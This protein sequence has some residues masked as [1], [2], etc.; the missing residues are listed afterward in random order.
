MLLRSF[1][2]LACAF[3]FATFSL[4]FISSAKAVEVTSGFSFN[5]IDFD[6]D[7]SPDPNSTT[8]ELT[9][10]PVS[11]QSQTGMSTGFVN[12]YAGGQWIVRNMP[13]GITE[14]SSTT[15]FALP[16]STDGVDDSGLTAYVDY[17]ASPTISFSAAA[18]HN[19]GVGNDDAG[20]EGDGAGDPS[21]PATAP[22]STLTFGG[23]TTAITYQ[24]NHPNIQTARNQCAPMALA[25]NLKWLQDT[26]GVTYVQGATT[27][28]HVTGLKGDPTNSIVGRLDVLMGRTGISGTTNTIANRKT[29]DG[30]FRTNNINGTLQFLTD[31]SNTG[32]VVKNEG[33]D[34]DG[35]T[36]LGGNFTAGAM[37]SQGQGNNLQ[38]SFILS[39][40]QAGDAV[41]MMWKYPNGG[42]H[43]VEVVGA[44]TVLGVNWLWYK[45]DNIQTN[46]KAPDGDSVGTDQ[47][48]WSRLDSS[49]V[50]VDEKNRPTAQFVI[51]EAVPEPGTLVLMALGGATLA[52]A[53]RRNRAA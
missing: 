23:P 24:F 53:C 36:G 6:W 31:T 3:A 18:T 27:Y 9:I 29:G 37:T 1:V 44:G 46:Q 43:A 38:F 47:L 10:D 40:L 49:N 34:S 20:G 13:L 52:L 26:Y 39:E 14:G 2:A 4:G 17:S 19:Y 16:G 35:V 7:T 32:M 33:K 5:Q 22:G 50:L 28:Q 42:G 15:S 8:G 48:D 25:N 21:G 45:S 12:A 51:T 30:T 41:Q 11:L